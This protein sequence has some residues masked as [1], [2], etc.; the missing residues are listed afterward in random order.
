MLT[1]DMLLR[2]SLILG[3]GLLLTGALRQQPAA[4]RHWLVAAALSLAVAQP[5]LNK[6][7]PEWPIAAISIL[8]PPS[9]SGT[10][11]EADSTVTF[12][13]P[14]D[15]VVTAT[16]KFDWQRFVA[17]VWLSGVAVSLAL[18]A[19]GAFWLQS[20]GVRARDAGA[21]WQDAGRE[22]RKQL[23]VRTSVRI[24]VS[25]HPA[26][27][28]TWGAIR[29]V[30]LLPA[31][32]DG[33]PS[34]RIR[35]VLAHELA[36]IVR[37]DWLIQLLAEVVRSIQWFNPLFW[38]A[39]ARLRRESEQACDDV[40]V[41][42]GV[43]GASY[44]SHLVALARSFSAYGR[45]WLPAPSIARPSTLERRVRAMLNPH[46]DRRPVSTLRRVTTALLLLAVA[47]PVA[48]A[49]QASST[50]TGKVT[51]PQ[52][53]PLPD[54]AVRLA[55]ISSDTVYE[56]RTDASGSFQIADIAPGE[57]LLSA[58]YPGFSSQ[59]QSVRLNGPVTFALQ[60]QVGTLRETVTVRGGAGSTAADL[61]ARTVVRAS[62]AATVP[63][64]GNTVVGGNIKPPMKVKD[65]RP[66]FRQAWVD[67]N[68]EGSVL[69][70]A[71]IGI[72]GRVKNV[73]VVSPVQADMEEE[74]IA[75]V[76]Q[77]E[78]TPTYLN[79]QA[80]EVRMFVTV[81]FAIER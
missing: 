10:A 9:S 22:L 3:T 72:D 70:Q 18:L 47:V 8:L 33:W 12:A 61:A 73:E 34:D 60:L 43:A 79:C 55:S 62:K 29:P 68:Q 50:T 81:T 7:M 74:A 13:P 56:A 71:L 26:L 37:R 44:A 36:H 63:A 78:F 6:V 45:T 54:A 42:S 64:C 48:M 52:G 46:T 14:M 58:R 4:L 80:I 27:L 39:C 16:E 19:A 75:A 35:I 66:R 25:E 65:V 76:T 32:A 20:L 30:I 67:A 23:G 24:A 28:V 38:I 41:A 5:V 11:E 59:R 15:L 69:L 31:G 21:A 51:D 49:A 40:V 2:S 53:L 17:A 1:A 77:W 57:Y